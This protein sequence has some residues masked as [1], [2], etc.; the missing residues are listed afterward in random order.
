ML[1]EQ[2]AAVIAERTGVARHRAAVVL[3]SGWQDAAAKIGTPSASIPMS[4]LPGFGEPTA[5]GHRNMV[6]SVPVDGGPVLVLMGRQHLYEG[7]APDQVVHG[8]RAA[9]AAGA[10]TVV[11]TNAVGGLRGGLHVGEPVLIGDHLNLTGRSPLTGAD[12]VDLVDAWDPALRGVARQ[13]GKRARGL[14]GR[15]LGL[16]PAGR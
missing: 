7:H 15:S 5:R 6:H 2:A 1:A 8:V 13:L 11:L 9:I 10:E 16:T 12:F 3:G 4:E 14:A